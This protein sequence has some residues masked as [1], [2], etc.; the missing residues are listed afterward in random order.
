MGSACGG[1]VGATMTKPEALDPVDGPVLRK[2]R[3]AFF[4]PYPIAEYL[5]QW[6]VR[7]GGL[8]RVLDPTCG[9]G[10]FLL[11]CARQLESSGVGPSEIAQRLHG[12][13][14]HAQSLEQSAHLLG[15]VG[16]GAQ[17]MTGDFFEEPTPG[18]VDARL[19]WMDAVIGNPPF[20]R[21]HE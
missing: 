12:I 16:A 19:P 9:E 10:V 8:G 17:L 4:T 13:D 20:V 11:A 7:G 1:S 15:E 6:A 3:G 18:Q 14:V 2:R 5:A 21:Y